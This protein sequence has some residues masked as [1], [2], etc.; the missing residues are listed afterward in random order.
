MSQMTPREIVQELDKHIVGQSDAKRAKQLASL[1]SVGGLLAEWDVPEPGPVRVPTY[2]DATVA[3]QPHG[4]IRLQWGF[5]AALF[6]LGLMIGANGALFLVINAVELSQ[7][8]PAFLPPGTGNA[9]SRAL[10]GHPGQ[11]SADRQQDIKRVHL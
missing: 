9:V 2:R 3:A 11:P 10:A 1:R 4:H 5:Q 8:T 6:L 7:T